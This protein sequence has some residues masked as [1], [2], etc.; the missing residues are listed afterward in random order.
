MI[1]V[2]NFISFIGYCLSNGGTPTIAPTAS[3]IAP[4]ASGIAPTD[5]G[6]SREGWEGNR[7]FPP[8]T[9]S[10][11]SGNRWFPPPTASG[12]ALQQKSYIISGQI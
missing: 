4:T 9:D 8:P 11:M 1:Y 5:S 6:M 12:I 3:G 10:G 7:W 2:P